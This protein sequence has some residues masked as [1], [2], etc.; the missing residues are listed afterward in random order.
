MSTVVYSGGVPI[1]Q[2][3]QPVTTS[4]YMGTS[5]PTS[6]VGPLSVAPG[7]SRFSIVSIVIGILIGMF[8][9]FVLLLI[10]YSQRLWL[11]TYC[12]NSNI[13]GCT[14]INY[15]NDPA[16]AIAV[17]NN[18]ANILFVDPNNQLL[19]KRPLQ[20]GTECVPYPDQTIV[21]N[22]PQVCNFTI[23]N[24]SQQGLNVGNQTPVYTVV[25]Q[26]SPITTIGSCVPA[27]GSIAT[28]GVPVAMWS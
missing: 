20:E 2:P 6:A 18:P 17:G 28:A 23:N 1:A 11:F 22:Y 4:L 9:V 24:V 21:I 8:I 10:A 14:G 7:R 16:D 25:G 3:V 26:P 19:Y 15:I 27:S 5:D 13:G 12:A